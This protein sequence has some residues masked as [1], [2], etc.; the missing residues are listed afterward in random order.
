MQGSGG[1]AIASLHWIASYLSDIKFYIRIG[2]ASLSAVP[3]NIGI[4]QWSVLRPIL[5]T[6]YIALIRRLFDSF[7]VGFH[8]YANHTQLY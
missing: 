1:G 8:K 2:A 4:P 7:G 3:V 5:F 6:A